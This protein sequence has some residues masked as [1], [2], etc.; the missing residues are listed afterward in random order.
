LFNS[1]KSGMDQTI[2]SLLGIRKVCAAHLLQLTFFMTPALVRHSNSILSCC[3]INFWD[4]K[5][6]TMIRLCIRF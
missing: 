6:S 4:K 2:A 3:L 5:W 1:W